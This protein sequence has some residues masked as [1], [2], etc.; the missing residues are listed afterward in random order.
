MVDTIAAVA[1]AFGEGGIGIIRISGERAREIL[2]LLFQPVANTDEA[3]IVNRRLMYGAKT[4][5]G[6]TMAL[7]QL[8]GKLSGRIREMRAELMD[9]L[10]S[11]AV[12]MDYPDEDIEE[13]EYEVLE[14]RISSIGDEVDQLRA[15]ADVGRLIREGLRVTIVGRPNVGKS[16]LMNALLGESRAIV[17]EIPGTTRDTIEEGI[18]IKGIPVYLTDTAGIRATEDEIERLGIEKSKEAFER[19][20]LI[21]LMIDASQPLREEDL[22]I[23][24]GIGERKVIVLLNKEDLGKKVSQSELDRILP[25]AVFID[26]SMPLDKGI[27]D[28]TDEIVAQVHRGN[29]RQENSMVVTNARQKALLD[30]ASSLL[31]DA[32]VMTRER[33][34]M[35]FIE[36]DLR[37]AW[38]TLGDILGE[39]IS[40]DIIDQVFARF[41]LGK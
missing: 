40:D 23:A 26:T 41:C 22:E 13:M 12:N 38:E 39:A 34:A 3:S 27:K 10:V 16:S 32:L 37:H 7:A 28:L 33:A 17:T 5:T 30:E 8:E 21:L 9:L 15:T 19:A 35:D 31:S 11:L 14:E 2:A 29:V 6:F 1:T 36:S 20:D 4:E 25:H 24:E 18:Q